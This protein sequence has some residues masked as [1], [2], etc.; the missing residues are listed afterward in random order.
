MIKTYNEFLNEKY[1]NFDLPDEK[2]I[3][4]VWEDDKKL[5]LERIII[6]KELRNNGYGTK[7]LNDIC[8]YSD[9]KNKPI[10]LTPDTSFGATSISRLKKFYKTF[11]FKNNK[12]LSVSQTMVRL[13]LNNKNN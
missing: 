13:S 11:G 10:F 9:K 7:I 1:I 5:V 8:K 4:E 6:P 3:L 12:D 2:I